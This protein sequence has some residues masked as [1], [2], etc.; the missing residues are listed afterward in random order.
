VSAKQGLSTGLAVVG[1]VAAGY[2]SNG[3]PQAIQ[4]GAKA[5]YAIGSVVGAAIFPDQAA[6]QPSHIDKR[7]ADSSYGK[8][9]IHVWGG[10][11]IPGNMI[12]TSPLEEDLEDPNS[13][14]GGDGASAA[15][16]TR[17]YVSFGWGICAGPVTAVRKVWLDQHLIYDVSATNLQLAQ[18]ILDEI[19]DPVGNLSDDERDKQRDEILANLD[20][21]QSKMRIYLGDESQMPS[22]LEEAYFGKGKVPAYRGLCKIEFEDLPLATYGNRR[23]SVFAEV[24]KAKT[25]ASPKVDFVP[26]TNLQIDSL[27]LDPIHERLYSFS[28]WGYY[29]VIDGVANTILQSGQL[30]SDE[31]WLQFSPFSPINYG[32]ANQYWIAEDQ[33]IYTAA[34]GP[35][36][37]IY[38]V[39]REP[40]GLSIRQVGHVDVN[41]V[42]FLQTIGALQSVITTPRF[43]YFACWG[44]APADYKIYLF[45]R[46]AET[47]RVS[48]GKRDGLEYQADFL[49]PGVPWQVVTVGEECWAVCSP[50]NWILGISTYL[51]RIDPDNYSMSSVDISADL[52]SGTLLAYDPASNC[53]VVH[54][55]DPN[56]L[57]QTRLAKFSLDTNTV[58]DT[59]TGIIMQGTKVKSFRR[60]IVGGSL[61]YS[62]DFQTFVQFN[63]STFSI[64]ATYDL[65]ALGFT[66]SPHI[67]GAI[68]DERM[69]AV[70]VIET[71]TGFA[72]Y[73]LHRI[74]YPGVLVADVIEGIM[75]QTGYDA[76]DFN[77]SGVIGTLQGYSFTRQTGAASNL[78]PLLQAYQI[79]VRQND[80]V[81]EFLMRGPRSPVA[82]WTIDDLGAREP[83]ENDAEPF[84]VMMVDKLNLPVRIYLNFVNPDTEYE[85]D[86]AAMRR[87]TNVLGISREETYSTPIVL[88]KAFAQRLA[89]RLVFERWSLFQEYT[90]FTHH[91]NLLVEP[92]DILRVTY[93]SRIYLMR[94]LRVDVGA[95]LI[96]EVHGVRYDP[97]AYID[98]ESVV[99]NPIG[100][101]PQVINVAASSQVFL[102]DIPLLRDTD[103]DDGFYIG[104]A[105]AG[106]GTTWPGA[107][108]YRSVDGATYTQV[109]SIRSPL[110]Y[111]AAVTA[112][113]D[114]SPYVFDRGHSVQVR[115]AFPYA[116]ASVSDAELL[117]GANPALLGDEIIQYGTATQISATIWEL[118]NLLRGRRGTDTQT[119]SHS[120]GER[121]VILDQN[122]LRRIRPGSGDIGVTRWYKA[123]TFGQQISTAAA[124]PF[125]NTA[126]GLWPYAPDHVVGERDG[127]N[128]L[129]ITWI[130]RTR[131]FGEWRDYVDV[132]LGETSESYELDIYDSGSVV[133]TITATSATA[134]YTAAEQTTDGLTPGDPIVLKLYQLSAIVGRGFARDATV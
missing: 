118:S 47:I 116:L 80:W 58:V 89:E 96:I 65:V 66:V 119:A 17:Y 115:L 73:Y 25:N 28:G 7:I 93:K 123:V 26:A 88:K 48:G 34:V 104:A 117:D 130:R 72:K 128:N 38:A 23:P 75:L 45:N 91:G 56:D 124:I 74:N 54:G 127:S 129:T 83:G 78:L 41:G 98:S 4:L 3:N 71:F 40:V 33:S 121:F 6:K 79:D 12:W 31:E 111:G 57:T 46:P 95:N 5:G 15:A 107:A 68:Y 53:L 133:R 37:Y 55:A 109:E 63:V 87:R 10:D 122:R 29:H 19:I 108:I 43:A 30:P 132:P 110:V 105:P 67:Y 112:L 44:N 14:K 9:I 114:G 102:L 50:A 36:G 77:V 39:E 134:S 97:N 90:C 60:G 42:I 99:N 49:M 8:P 84:D 20:T 22:P 51:V 18:R 59:V 101:V 35:A 106:S 27:L 2:L 125:V 52:A 86:T 81:I 32:D 11:K 100:V 103:D 126:K 64:Q 61:W 120:A 1:A 13:G 76:A 69:D 94:V 21:V 131:V 70:W 82:D 113:G 62:Q 24:L 85:Q 92:S 16:L